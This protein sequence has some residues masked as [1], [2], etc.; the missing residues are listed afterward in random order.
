MNA[1]DGKTEKGPK[2]EFVH[3]DY[4]QFI[5]RDIPNFCDESLLLKIARCPC[6]SKTVKKKPLPANRKG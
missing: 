3:N 1:G 2:L 6:H 4:T 5:Q